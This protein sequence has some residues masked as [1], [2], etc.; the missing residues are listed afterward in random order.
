MPITLTINA[1]QSPYTATLRRTN[2]SANKDTVITGIVASP[3]TINVKIPGTYTLTKLADNGADEADVSASLPVVL[4]INPRAKALLAGR[5]EICDDGVSKATLSMNFTA[6]VSP[7]SVKLRR[8]T[9]TANDTTYIAITQDPFPVSARVIGTSPTRYRIVE[10]RDANNCPG[11]TTSGSA[12]VS[13]KPSPSA[14]ISGLDSICPGEPATL[15]IALSPTSTPN[16]SFT[17]LKD[18]ATPTTIGTL[19]SYTYN[20]VVTNPGIY[21]LANVAD[22]SCTGKVSGTGTIRSYEL[23]TATITGTQT[24]CQH[25]SGNLS[26]ALTGHTPWRYKY[27][28]VGVDTTE[29][30]GVNSSPN[31]ISVDKA[32][33]YNLLEVYD[34]NCKGTVSGSAIVTITPAPDVELTGLAAAYDKR[35][36]RIIPLTGT[37]EGTP[38]NSLF[39]GP[40][41]YLNGTQYSFFPFAA[42]A[43]TN[44]IVYS[45]RVSSTSCWGYDTSVVRILEANSI[46]EFENN[47][48][49]YCTNDQ[50]FTVTGTNIDGKI[51]SF[52]ITGG[53]GLTDHGSN[54]A[55]VSPALLSPNIYTI[56][57]TY[58]DAGLPQT[59]QASFD[60]GVSPVADFKGAT[61]CF[62]AGQSVS[63]NNTSVSNFG[64][65]SDTLF[66]W[67]ILNKTGSGY[68]VNDTAKDISYT[69]AESGNYNVSLELYNSWGCYAN[70]TKTF[71]LRP[72]IVPAEETRNE[73]FETGALGW[74]KSSSSDSPNSWMLGDP[75]R[76]FSD[77][78]SGANCWYT[79]TQGTRPPKEQSWVTSPCYDFR[80]TQKPMLK[81]QV[82]RLFNSNRDG[83]NVQFSADSGKTWTPLGDLNDGISWYNYTYIPGL[84]GDN[85]IGWCVHPVTNIGNDTDWKEVKH[86]LDILKGQP[87]VQFRIAYGSDGSAQN[88][89]GIAFDNFW[90]GERKRTALIEHFTNSSDADCLE[91][92]SLLDA[93]TLDNELSVINIQYHTSNPAGDPFYEDNPVIPSTREFYYGISDVPYALLN[94]GV[95]SQHSFDYQDGSKPL[96]KNVAII[97]SLREANFDISISSGY[98]NNNILGVEVDLVALKTLPLTELSVRVVVIEREIHGING[99]NGDTLFRN[100]VKAMLPGAAGVSINKSW[101]ADTHEKID[102]EWPVQDVYDPL[103]LRLVAFVQDEATYE[104]YQVKSDTIGGEV[105]IFNPRPEKPLQKNFIVYPNPASH[106]AFVRFE[107]ELT[108]GIQINLYNNTGSLVYSNRIESGNSMVEI[109][110]ADLPDGIYM[111][112]MTDKNQLLGTHKLIISR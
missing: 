70:T 102:L 59:K 41:V 111:L 88:N 67:K 68:L 107:N 73:E 42:P 7:W 103:Q 11:D 57:Y 93:F 110:V 25:T 50:P 81:M 37:P 108:T 79:L 100:V 98:K 99:N 3:R 72:T 16:W 6:G 2:S 8:G 85:K 92:D 95:T 9:N 77:P 63:L 4:V 33:T 40:G 28:L 97:E 90:I 61:E 10:I 49:K 30:I 48:T 22:V 23:P 19:S 34:K 96:N 56:T 58:Y 39:S 109:P 24:I 106:S 55:T 20:L 66:Y 76:G 32:G 1:G 43:G 80:G 52:T 15:T 13:Y 17:Y 87:Q 60:V 104:I 47:R 5:Y 89:N 105:G 84:I 64:F 71:A 51:G 78:F 29:F 18:G 65:L 94:G 62:Q 31:V 27:R 14:T 101:N 44:N 26:V 91:A 36:T 21:T 46:I 69:F 74:T 54:T 83:A 35:D 38:G 112:R 12:W 82:W 75:S 45:Y 86:S 53:I